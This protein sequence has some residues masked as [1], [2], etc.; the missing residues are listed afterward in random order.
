MNFG[1]NDKQAAQEIRE[2]MRMPGYQRIIQLQF[3]L[4]EAI[5]EKGK[6]TRPDSTQTKMWAELCGFDRCYNAPLT[7]VN[8]VER[9]E[10]L[11][12]SANE[13]SKRYEEE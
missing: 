10:N 7:F 3:Q 9:Q 2:L 6:K 5:L 1:D 4:R 11:E 12:N 8:Q 13:V